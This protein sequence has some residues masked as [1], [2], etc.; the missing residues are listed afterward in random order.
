MEKTI[1]FAT[2]N[3]HKA[4][5]IRSILEGKYIVKTLTDINLFDEIPENGSTFEE[6]SFIKADYVRCRVPENTMCIADDSGLM[7]DALG[8]MPGVYSA[9]YAGEPSDDK[10]NVAKLLDNLLGVANRKAKFVTVITAVVNNEVYR[11]RGE[12]EGKIIEECRGT[13]GFGY[14][15]VFVP[16]GYDATFAQLPAEVKNSISHRARATGKFIQ[17]INNIDNK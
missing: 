16:D 11:F 17:F 10:R 5:E 4:S 14:D 6:N 12:I 8:G 1:V 15:P 9:R 2:H 13:N 3:A 7:V